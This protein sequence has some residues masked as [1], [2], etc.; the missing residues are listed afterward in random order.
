MVQKYKPLKIVTFL[1]YHSQLT[2][3][4]QL[5]KRLFV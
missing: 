3:E 1:L 5:N 2:K 4:S